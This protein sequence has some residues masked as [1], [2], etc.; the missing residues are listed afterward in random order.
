MDYSKY[1]TDHL[2][3]M[4]FWLI[5]TIKHTKTPEMALYAKTELEEL[6]KEIWKRLQITLQFPE[7]EWDTQ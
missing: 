4:R 5:H 7:E 2:N 1:E 6:Q 3:S